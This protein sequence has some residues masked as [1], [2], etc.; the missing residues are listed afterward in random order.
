MTYLFHVLL[1]P[2]Y[3]VDHVRWSIN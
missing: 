3:R 1:R 2:R